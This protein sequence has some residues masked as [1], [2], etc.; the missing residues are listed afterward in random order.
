MEKSHAFN[1]SPC[2]SS[3]QVDPPDSQKENMTVL[4]RSQSR[5]NLKEGTMKLNK[6]SGTIRVLF[7]VFY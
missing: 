2:V 4:G 7:M 6:D 3:N 1:N 5:N